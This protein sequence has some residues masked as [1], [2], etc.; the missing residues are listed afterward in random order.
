MS[1]Y[2]WGGEKPA[3]VLHGAAFAA[4]RLRAYERRTAIAIARAQRNPSPENLEAVAELEAGL[5]RLRTS[6]FDECREL[7]VVTARAA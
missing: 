4:R 2:K 3:T 7:R 6:P 1:H 5:T